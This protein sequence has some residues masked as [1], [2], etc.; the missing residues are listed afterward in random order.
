[1][2]DDPK[3]NKPPLS[4]DE[5]QARVRSAA[6]APVDTRPVQ[7]DRSDRAEDEEARREALSDVA[8][9]GGGQKSEVG[10]PYNG[11]GEVRRGVEAAQHRVSAPSRVKDEEEK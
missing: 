8:E 2:A 7:G 9:T 3:R 5:E 10:E 4:P 1:M 11:K 6:F